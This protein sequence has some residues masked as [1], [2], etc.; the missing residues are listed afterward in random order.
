MELILTVDNHSLRSRHCLK[1][2][3]F[4]VFFFNGKYNFSFV[5]KTS[6]RVRG[7][8]KYKR[9]EKRKNSIKNLKKSWSSCLNCLKH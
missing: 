5:S 3:T 6:Q 7:E 1:K 4:N 9:K 2:N 8:I